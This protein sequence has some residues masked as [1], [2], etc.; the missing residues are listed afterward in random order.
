[1]PHIQA[2]G[3]YGSQYAYAQSAMASPY[4]AGQPIVEVNARSSLTCPASRSLRDWTGMFLKP[5]LLWKLKS[6][7]GGQQDVEFSYITGGMRWEATYNAV[8]PEKGDNLDIVG[9]VT[10]ENMSGKDFEDSSIKLMAGDVARARLDQAYAV[11]G[12]RRS[13][14]SRRSRESRREPLM[15]ITYIHCHGP[16]P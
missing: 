16:Q 14:T 7:V 15:S 5:T 11:S 10:L 4:V 13:A 6:A 3:S 12:M 2:F 9:W 8:A 1:V